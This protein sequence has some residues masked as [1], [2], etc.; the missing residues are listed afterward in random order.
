M[1]KRCTHT[2]Q[3]RLTEQQHR[4]L[5]SR[6]KAEGKSM[7]GLVKDLILEDIARSGS[8]DEEATSGT[9]T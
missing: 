7:G 2:L 5:K 1:E 6:A 4:Y 3:V 9:N 8:V